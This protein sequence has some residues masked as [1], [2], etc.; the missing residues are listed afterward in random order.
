MDISA[1]CRFRVLELLGL[2]PETLS[3]GGSAKAAVFVQPKVDSARE[4]WSWI[5]KNNML[6][7]LPSEESFKFSGMIEAEG[8]RRGD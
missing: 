8:I 6:D 4:L 7:T 2:D 3:K 1:I 5:I